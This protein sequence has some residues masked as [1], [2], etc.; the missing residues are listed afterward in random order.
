MIK[1]KTM[2]PNSCN[3]TTS[4]ISLLRMVTPFALRVKMTTSF[5]CS[6]ERTNGELHKD[7]ILE[8]D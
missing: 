1:L 8:H 4:S 5:R 6:P 2:K 3:P 7:G